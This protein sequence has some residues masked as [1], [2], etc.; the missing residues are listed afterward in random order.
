WRPRLSAAS[1]RASPPESSRRTRGGRRGPPSLPRGVHAW[2]ETACSGGSR[3][4]SNRR[5]SPASDNAEG[6]RASYLPRAGTQ[7]ARLFA[8]G[9]VDATSGQGHNSDRLFVH[10]YLTPFHDFTGALAKAGFL[11]QRGGVLVRRRAAVRSAVHASW[12][13]TRQDDSIM[14]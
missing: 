1:S 13:G 6:H 8:S 14:L 5:G 3:P 7:A 11:R 12:S 9:R 10:R 4:P 2:G